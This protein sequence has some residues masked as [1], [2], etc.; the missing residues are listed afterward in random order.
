MEW[1]RAAA[2]SALAAEL[3]AA[4]DGETLSQ[5][6]ETVALAWPQLAVDAGAFAKRLADAVRTTGTPLQKLAAADVLLAQACL[7][8]APT[9]LEAL[10]GLMADVAESLTRQT[11][12]DLADEAA[13]QTRARLLLA[14]PGGTPKLAGYDGRGSLFSFLRVATLNT[15][16]NLLSA[17][18]R[19]GSDGDDAL[20]QLPDMVDLEARLLRA[21]QQAHF[22]RAFR[23]AVKTLTS[24]QRALL[25][26]NLIDGLSIDELAP[27]Y[28]AHRSSLARWLSEAR[29]LLAERTRDLLAAELQLPAAEVESLIRSAQSQL[30]VS[31]S[32]VLRESQNEPAPQ[33]S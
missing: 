15:L 13:Q 22:R 25:R 11:S 32:R 30:D 3:G 2:R 21:D 24:R 27:M 33:I 23:S 20:A 31:L 14:E 26:F 28:Q 16:R 19:A 4:V 7:L 6:L 5:C 9:A 8:G 29:Q 10:D 12:A 18:R 17:E 1:D